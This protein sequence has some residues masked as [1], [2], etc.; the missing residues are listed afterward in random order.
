MKKGRGYTAA[1]FLIITL[2]VMIRN[3]FIAGVITRI[4]YRDREK[5]ITKSPGVMEKNMS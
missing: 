5:W 4:K 2:Y 3:L 1:F